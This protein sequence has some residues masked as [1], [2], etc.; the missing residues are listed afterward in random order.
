MCRLRIL[1]EGVHGAADSYQ[2]RRRLLCRRFV[3]GTRA[4][5]LQ[6]IRIRHEG[7]YFAA[8]SYQARGR[9]LCGGFVTKAFVRYSKF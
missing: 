9:S 1:H 3:S 6:R 5:T 8:D 4:F 7:V 2:A